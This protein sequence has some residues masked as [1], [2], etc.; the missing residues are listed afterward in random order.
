MNLKIFTNVHS[1]MNYTN[2]IESCQTHLAVQYASNIELIRQKVT[3][4][5]ID[6]RDTPESHVQ[7]KLRVCSIQAGCSAFPFYTTRINR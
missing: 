6:K 4:V 1:L 7:N 3:R 5:V 2:L